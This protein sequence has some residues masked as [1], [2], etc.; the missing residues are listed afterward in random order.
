VRASEADDLAFAVTLAEEAGRVVM[1]RYERRQHVRHKSAK[2]V[3]TEADHLS[4]ELMI[5][6][7]RARHPGDGIL[8]EESGEHDAATTGSV[9]SGRG[10]IW[11]LD[12]LDGTV[13]YANGIPFFCVSVALVVDGTPSVGVIHDPTRAELFAATAHGPATLNGHRIRV[14]EKALLSDCVVALALSGRSVASRAGAVRR[15]VRVTRSMG[16]SALSLAYVANGRFDAFA[17]QSGQFAWDV[18]A[19]GLIAGRAGAVVSDLEGGPWFDLT[20][21]TRSWGVLAAP[22]AVHAPLLELV[23]PVR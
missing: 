6:S 13:N 5:R 11:V 12:P 4:E 22:A 21:G 7:I 10:R 9:T 14:G 16:S 23:R 8:A 15:A 2:D 20:R 3:V 17:Q 1:E 19:A 18:A